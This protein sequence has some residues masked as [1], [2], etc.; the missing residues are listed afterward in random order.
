MANGKLVITVNSIHRRAYTAGDLLR[1]SRRVVAVLG[2]AL[3]RKRLRRGFLE[4]L[5]HVIR[6]E[7]PSSSFFSSSAFP[8]ATTAAPS[9]SRR[10]LSTVAVSTKHVPAPP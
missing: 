5:S 2:V 8:V 9:S 7:A 3:A 6:T 1:R 4:L 10:R